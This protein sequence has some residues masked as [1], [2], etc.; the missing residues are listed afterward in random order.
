MIGVDLQ[1]GQGLCFGMGTG[2]DRQEARTSAIPVALWPRHYAQLLCSLL[3]RKTFANL[4]HPVEYK[5][6][7]KFERLISV[8]QK[9]PSSAARAHSPPFCALCLCLTEGFVLHEGYFSSSKKL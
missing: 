8:Y 1:Q 2:L 9:L 6:G 4:L 7:L 3:Q 5:H